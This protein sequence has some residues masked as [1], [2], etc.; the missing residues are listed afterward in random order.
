MEIKVK[1]RTLNNL[2]VLEIKDDDGKT[3]EK[4]FLGV[5]CGL[6]WPIS[7]NPGGYYCLVAQEAK[8]LITGEC[9]LLVIKEFQGLT[10]E[11]LFRRM[12]DEMGMFGC[13][14]IFTVVSKKFESYLLAL[15][16]YRRSTRDLQDIKI[17][18]APFGDM[19]LQSFLHG[20]DMIA[21][22]LKVIKGLTIPKESGIRSQ[23]RE[24]R[25]DDLKGE[26]HEKFFAVNALRYVLGAFQTSKV[27]E[28][29]KNRRDHPEDWEVDDLEIFC[30]PNQI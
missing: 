28:S 25:E 27:P 9:P 24:I 26:P 21:K 18:P 29:T 7:A 30:P 22:W 17:L 12:F 6:S 11:A 23:L 1:G 13:F 10:M 4:T 3:Q 15:D 16:S 2:L 20:N 19:T 8:R 14:E 5:R